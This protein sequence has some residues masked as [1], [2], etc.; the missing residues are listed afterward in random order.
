MKIKSGVVALILATTACSASAHNKN[1]QKYADIAQFGIPLTAGAISLYKGDTEGLFQLA[2]GA[3]YT[4][5][6]THV[7]K[8]SVNAERPNGGDHSFPS[9][10][11]SAATQGAAYLQFRYGWE[12]GVPAYAAAAL[13]GYSRVDSKHHYWRDVAAGAAL[14]TGIQY[15]VSEMGYSM[16]NYVISPYVSG[17]EVGLYASINF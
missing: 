10:H 12:Y 11:T 16:S 7:I 5:V 2:E 4:A 8:F 13:V 6:A 14:A 1:L 3:L 17:D 9:G 15:V